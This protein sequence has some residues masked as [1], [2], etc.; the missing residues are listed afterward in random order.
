VSENDAPEPNVNAPHNAAQWP[1]AARDS[2]D[3]DHSA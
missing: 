1:V 2:S 3:T